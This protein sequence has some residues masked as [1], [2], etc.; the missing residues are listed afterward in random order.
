MFKLKKSKTPGP[1]T[2][3]EATGTS[4]DCIK[5]IF[6]SCK[7][8]ELNF[9]LF[10]TDGTHGSGT[11]IEEYEE[12]FKLKNNL[13]FENQN[14]DTKEECV[15]T[16]E[17]GITYLIIQ[18]RIVKV[19]YGHCIPVSLDEIEYLKKLR[20]ISKTVIDSIG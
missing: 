14:E 12:C 5:Q 4:V 1:Y 16:L 3:N 13:D 20:D 15:A 17:I 8:D 2:V 9:I 19:Y 7:P 11:T 6:P 10:S 18:P